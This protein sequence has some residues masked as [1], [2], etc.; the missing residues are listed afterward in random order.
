MQ[1]I[2]FQW[3]GANIYA[4]S[5][6][7]YIGLVAGVVGG[8]YAAML[9]GLDLARTSTAMLLLILPALVG[10]RLLFVASHWGVFR[11][12][13][14]R[15][16]RQSEG[17]AA[18]YGGLLL[19]FLLSLPLLGALGLSVGAFWDAATFTILIGMIFTRV[20]C[21]L[22]GCCAGRPADGPFALYLPNIHGVWCRRL[23]TQLLEAGLAVV[24][25]A[26][27]VILW[28]RLP[29]D[30]ALFV[31]NLAAYGVG[32]CGLELTRETSD[33]VGSV[34]LHQAISI[35]LVALAVATF[36]YLGARSTDAGGGEWPLGAERAQTPEFVGGIGRSAWSFLLAPPAVLA[37]LLLFH[38]VGCGFPGGGLGDVTIK[39]Y[40][41]DVKSDNPVS[42]WRLQETD[43]TQPAKNEM[44]GPSGTYKQEIVPPNPPQS[45]GSP[46][47]IQLKDT[48]VLGALGLLQADPSATAMQVRG[49]SVHAPLGAFDPSKTFTVEALVLP[50]WD[51][52]NTGYFFTLIE[53]LNQPPAKPAGFGIYAGPDP[54]HKDFYEW[55]VWV[56]TSGGKFERLQVKGP[57]A[58]GDNGPRINDDDIPMPL[59]ANWSMYLALT[60][61]GGA[62]F[63][64]SF[65]YPGRDMAKSNAYPLSP[66]SS[67]YQPN[68]THPLSV[69]IGSR[70]SAIR[71]LL[72]GKIEE[73]AIYNGVPRIL[74]HGMNAFT[75]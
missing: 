48:V 62:N 22:N 1:P 70:Y 23:P 12:Q 33:R 14:R 72:W 49:G 29:F 65:Y 30:G 68:K 55:Q 52:T 32:R 44:G 69:G 20:G 8:T 9:Q 58:P 45:L 66:P 39:D 4:Y 75:G 28:N 57:L 61:D 54:L 25:L 51:M 3:R 26:G 24:L 67:A 74:S 17:G 15:I 46:V 37:V 36:M 21:L 13:P 41:D 50:E 53:S 34:R 16:W 6:M 27:S 7:L 64:L 63:V 43:W 31:A 56:A 19:S 59:P 38:F 35:G 73:V 11:G 47:N 10:S 71:F 60:Y 5:A 18:M 42:Y 40:P 2:L